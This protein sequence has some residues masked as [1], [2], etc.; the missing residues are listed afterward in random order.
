MN[1]RWLVKASLWARNPPSMKKVIFVLAI[2]GLCIALF[3]VER[4]VGWP[5]WLTVNGRSGRLF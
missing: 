3:V 4:Y 5:N 2:I 1:P